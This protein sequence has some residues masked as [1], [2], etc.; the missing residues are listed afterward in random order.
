MWTKWVVLGGRLVGADRHEWSHDARDQF[1]GPEPSLE[2]PLPAHR[3]AIEACRALLTESYQRSLDAVSANETT[4][5]FLGLLS[6]SEWG[7]VPLADAPMRV[8]LMGRTM[9]GKSTLLAA[10][11]GSS[12]ERIGDGRQRYSRD[13]FAARALQLDNVEIVDTPG[14]G[15]KDGEDDLAQAMAQ[16]SGADLILWIASNDSFQEETAQ[17]LRAVAL[18]GK[19]V[20]V[21]L[22]CRAPLADDLDR[23]DFLEDQDAVF[24]QHE[25]HFRTIRTHLSTAAVRPVAEVMLHAEAARQALAVGE[26]D[27]ELWEASR[28]RSVLA[29][30]EQESKERRTGRRVLRETDHVRSRVLELTEVLAIIEQGTHEIVDFARGMREDQELRTARLINACSQRMEDDVV[31]IVGNR[32]GWYG[33]VTDFGPQ[34][35]EL[36]EKEQ[37]DLVAELDEV[38]KARCNDLERA[39]DDTRAETERE[40]T[41]AVRGRLKVEGLHDFRGLWKGRVAGAVVGGGGALALMAFGMAV[42]STLGPAGTVVGAL[43]GIAINV[44]GSFLVTPL[45]KK[46]QSFFISKGKI[47]EANRQLLQTEIGKVLALLEEEVMAELSGT[48]TRIREDLAHVFA[49]HAEAEVDSLA[50]ANLVSRQRQSLGPAISALDHATARCLLSADGRPRLAASVGKV[51]RLPGVCTAIEMTSEGLSEAWLFPP[52]SPETMIFGRAPYQELPGA[53]AMSYVAGLTEEV[54]ASIRCSTTGTTV[55]TNAPVP[56]QIL[57]AWSATLSDHLGSQVQIVHNLVPRGA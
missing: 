25:G 7:D 23:E 42:G 21:A 17:A 50:V 49:G 53:R 45:R 10:L 5:Q 26:T 24:A 3:Q 13:V 22:N 12:E 34:V 39:I 20:V 33:S 46:V 11:T 51:T 37:S 54:P 2:D 8:V 43:A 15:A 31:R 1:F 28:L 44:A 29:I 40:W 18:R 6:P 9:A 30:L 19:P 47:L 16:V 35:A 48:I 14:V 52:S 57:D 38:L 55:T 32:Q 56:N 41:T 4:R 36:W 27:V